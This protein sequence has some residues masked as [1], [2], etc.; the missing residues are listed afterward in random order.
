MTAADRDV[1]TDA[2]THKHQ[3]NSLNTSA[4]KTLTAKILSTL[5]IVLDHT[6]MVISAHVG[7]SDDYL[8]D[9]MP[10]RSVFQMYTL[11]RYNNNIITTVYFF[12]VSTP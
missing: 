5:N 11:S 1:K 12:E 8:T 3:V 7:F 2:M 4:Q 9:V 10:C 6:Y